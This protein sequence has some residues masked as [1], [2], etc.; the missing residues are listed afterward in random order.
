MTR[1]TSGLKYTETE[2]SQSS[3]QSAALT[4]LGDKSING[5]IHRSLVM[6]MC[7]AQP[8]RD[9][10]SFTFGFTPRYFTPLQSTSCLRLCFRFTH[11]KNPFALIYT[12]LQPSYIT[13]SY[14]RLPPHAVTRITFPP[15]SHASPS[16]P[17]FPRPTV[18]QQSRT[19][20]SS[21][22]IRLER[23]K[24]CRSKLYTRVDIFEWM[25]NIR[26]RGRYA[27]CMQ[28]GVCGVI[29]GGARGG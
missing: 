9:S 28:Y 20:I 3:D 22:H 7:T 18:H 23:D 5:L 25:R 17:R 10:E 24:P 21:Y 29:K 14:H 2:S 26:A 11:A 1:S 15:I 16:P 6:P 27:C 19:R 8:R 12:Y 13:T 4:L